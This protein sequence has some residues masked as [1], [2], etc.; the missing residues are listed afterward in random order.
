MTEIDYDAAVDLFIQFMD[1]AIL[2]GKSFTQVND[3]W[4][5]CKGI[6]LSWR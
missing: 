2:D 1:G 5:Y 6:V 4:S 3:P